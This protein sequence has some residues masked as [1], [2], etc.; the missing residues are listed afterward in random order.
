MGLGSTLKLNWSGEEQVT[1]RGRLLTVINCLRSRLL[2]VPKG[3]SEDAVSKGR[4]LSSGRGY[5]KV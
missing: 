5:I 1:A 3:G 2:T 4:R